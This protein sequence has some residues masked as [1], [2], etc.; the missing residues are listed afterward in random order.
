MIFDGDLFRASRLAGL[1]P[2]FFFVAGGTAAFFAGFFDTFLV[3]RAP[4]AGSDAV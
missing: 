1:L 2:A 3:A 4:F